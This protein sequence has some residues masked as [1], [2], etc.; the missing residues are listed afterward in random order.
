MDAKLSHSKIL[1]RR[2]IKA[3]APPHR[4]SVI[5]YTSGVFDLFHV[6]HLN[7]IRNAR[8]L[9]DFLIVGVSSDELV[10]EYKART[11]V[12]PFNERA[13][14]VRSLRFVDA[15]VPQNSRSK[16]EAHDRLNFDHLFVGDD[17]YQDPRWVE[18][19]GAL[20]S[21]GVSITY[22]PYTQGT[23]STRLNQVL[24]KIADSVP[25]NTNVK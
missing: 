19:D 10:E 8:A 6:G 1:R 7:L 21:R 9:C 23:S 20:K 5:G 17:W 25:L 11:P 16:I 13:E 3:F 14:I 15:V 4:Q 22:F 18:F 12:I 24:S 2:N